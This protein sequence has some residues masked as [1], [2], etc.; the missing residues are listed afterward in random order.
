[1]KVLAKIWDVVDTVVWWGIW[2]VVA[3][4]F[5]HFTGHILGAW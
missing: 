2:F 4:A 5:V 3:F 1:M